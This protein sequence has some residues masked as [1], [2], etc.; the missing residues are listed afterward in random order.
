MRPVMNLYSGFMNNLTLP[1]YDLVRGTS[2]FRS[3]RVLQKT[4]WLS[5]ESLTH[6]QN[7]NLRRVIRHAYETVP[8]YQRVFKQKGVHPDDIR[9]VSDLVKLPVLTK[10]LI[11]KNSSDMLSCGYPVKKLVPYRSGGSSGNQLRFFVTKDQQSWEIAAEYRAYGWAGYRL[12]DKC[13][14]F[15]ASHIDISRYKS[16]ESRFASNLERVFI[17]D[18]Y[19]MS[20]RVLAKF[21]SL[22]ERYRPKIVRGYTSS[23]YLM[24]KYLVDNGIDS[25][26]PEA[27]IT[28]AET[29]FGSMRETIEKAFGCQ[30]FDFYGSREIGGL[31]GE[32]EEHSGYHVSTENVAMEFIKDGEQVEA[33]EKGVVYVTSLRNFGMPFIRYK[34][35]DVA[36]PSKDLCSCGRG[37][38]LLHSVEGR[39][40]DFMAVYDKKLHKVAPL[41]PMYPLI[42]YGLMKV[43]LRSVRVVQSSL[44]RLDV[45]AVKGPGYSEKDTDLL[46][47][48]F[49]SALG[50]DIEI[51]FNFLDSL[52]PLA[53]GKRTVFISK[54]NPFE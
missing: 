33:G 34:L 44:N 49:Q 15:W 2:R 13:L 5:P 51:E 45:N 37:L 27:V 1:F 54:I 19:V 53:S 7:Q 14:M 31:A 29:L 48:H 9:G 42:I 20:N 46:R 3:A 18:T 41:G 23:V 36:A 52:P 50:D 22:L 28:G 39:I 47:E 16:F 40:S 4:Q 32:C 6:L 8:Y 11:R 21:A 24:A 35:G 10:E 30:V 12:G 17:L 43:P 38:P 26:R 25:V